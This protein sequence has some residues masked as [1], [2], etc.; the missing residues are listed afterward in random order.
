MFK[1]NHKP[2]NF[3]LNCKGKLILWDRPWVMGILNITSD[4]FFAGSRFAEPGQILEKAGQMIA[5]GADIIDIGG[6]STRPGSERLSA[7]EEI[8]KVIPV[9]ELLSSKTNQVLLSVDTYHAAVAHAAVEAGASIVNDISAGEMDPL[10]LEVVAAL[11]VPYIC[12]HMKGVPETMHKNILYEDIVTEVLDF[13]SRK[14]EACKAAGI[15]DVIIDPGFGFGKTISHNFKLLQQ[16][17]KFQ[18]LQ[19]PVMAGVSRKSLIY[20]T[21]GIE[22]EGSLNGTSVLNTIALLQGALLLRVHDVKAA[23]EAVKLVTAFSQA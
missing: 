3:T 18:L 20:R 9:L 15:H 13:F 8:K 2:T 11:R 14:L 22:P 10:M 19:R 23:T 16:L 6:Q 4:S 12:M 7:S 5:E 1:S 17:A 21:L